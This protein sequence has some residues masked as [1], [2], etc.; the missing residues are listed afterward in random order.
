MPLRSL[1]SQIQLHEDP[2]GLSFW[3]ADGERRV[4]VFAT[5]MALHHEMDGYSGPLDESHGREIFNKQREK[6]ERAASRK[7]DTEGLQGQL[8][9]APALFV[10]VEDL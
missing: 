1:Y 6:I 10:T 2:E 5:F 8:S 9:G 4:R 3:M 7:Y